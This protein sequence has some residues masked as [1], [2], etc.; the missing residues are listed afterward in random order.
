MRALLIAAVALAS[1]SAAPDPSYDVRSAPPSNVA[2]FDS[3]YHILALC[4]VLRL[5]A[6]A[7][8]RHDDMKSEQRAT[9]THFTRGPNQLLDYEVSFQQQ[10]EREVLVELRRRPTANTTL[11]DATWAKVQRCGNP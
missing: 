11:T 5:P 2:T 8:L 10:T 9:L 7:Q 1:C 3:L 6:S 4:V